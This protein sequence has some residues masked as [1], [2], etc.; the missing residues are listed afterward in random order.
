MKKSSEDPSVP[1]EAVED[2]VEFE[3]RITR[4][5]PAE[6]L[7]LDNLCRAAATDA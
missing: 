1:S 6:I 5:A 3:S 7:E 4:F 2:F